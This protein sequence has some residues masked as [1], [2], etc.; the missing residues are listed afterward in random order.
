MTPSTGK[1]FLAAVLLAAGMAIVAERSYAEEATPLPAAT[2]DETPGSATSETIVLAGG[3]FWGVQGVFQ[4]VEGVTSA[5]S[6]YAGGESVDRPVRNGGWRRYGPRGIGASHLRSAQGELRPTA[7][8][9]F[10]GRARSDRTQPAGTGHRHAISFSDI[11]ANAEQASIAK[12]YI[13]QLNQ[14]RVFN[15]AIVTR[16]EPG[17]AFYPAE[18]YHQDFL[19]LH[20]DYPYIVYQRPAEDC[21]VEDD[22]SRS[23]SGE[24]G[25]G[26][27][28]AIAGSK[29]ATRSSRAQPPQAFARRFRVSH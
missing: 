11:S 10:L 14:A 5:V 8:G 18:G 15:A 28:D 13:A 29:R 2:A 20:P 6:G 7:A 23:L 21:G 22:V 16:I 9:L 1:K 4:H 26:W 24:A 17:H 19:T 27:S 12:A 25:S 3:C